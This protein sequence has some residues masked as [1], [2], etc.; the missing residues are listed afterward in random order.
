VNPQL[1]GD[2]KLIDVETGVPQDVTVDETM[3]E[4]YIARLQAWQAQI[5]GYC[6]RRGMHYIAAN[7]S[8]PW[9]QLILSE[10]RQARVVQ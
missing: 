9:E 7:T 5:D 8:T 4:L 2:L 3:R 6:T 1:T 10:L